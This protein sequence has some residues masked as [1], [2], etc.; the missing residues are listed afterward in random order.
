[1]KWEHKDTMLGTKTAMAHNSLDVFCGPHNITCYLW[2][3]QYYL[4]FVDITCYL[5]PPQCTDVLVNAIPDILVP[6]HA[7]MT[8][9]ERS[10][11]AY[12]DTQVFTELN[13]NLE[14]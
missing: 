10:L 6:K 3:P 1:M 11:I 5:W 12:E 7:M 9:L 8:I 14:N 2:P 13:L 4:L